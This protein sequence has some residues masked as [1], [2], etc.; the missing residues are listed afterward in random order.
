MDN[1]VERPVAQAKLRLER[2]RAKY[3]LVDVVVRVFK[4][5]SETDGGSYAAAL[6]YYTFFSIFPLLA[7]TAAILGF[8]TDGDPAAQQ[9][10]REGMQAFP[11]FRDALKPGGFAAIEKARQ[12][13]ALTGGV[14]ALYAGSGAIVALEPALK[15]VHRIDEEPNFLEKRLRSLKWL[16]I[17]GAAFLLSIVVNSVAGAQSEGSDVA[18]E[19]AG[20][21]LRIPG[22]LISIAVFATAYKV[23]PAKAQSWKEVLPG[24]IVAGVVFTLLVFL[25]GVFVA[26]GEESRN[27]TFGAFAAAATLLIVCF[28]SARITLLSAEVNAVLA[29][30]RL[31]RQP[32]TNDQGGTT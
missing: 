13:L 16:A 6:T 7:L 21:L 25:G 19:I 32:A 1:P 26:S 29:E 12:E 11:M 17:L 5:F 30:R 8:I 15:K 28:L 14:L 9:R 24:S 20:L 10:F 3:G 2:A 18:G 22:V 27:A 31:T 23:L 4:R